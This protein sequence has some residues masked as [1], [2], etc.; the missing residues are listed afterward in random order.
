MGS[1]ATPAVARKSK[2]LRIA[3]RIVAIVAGVLALVFSIPFEVISITT[4]GIEQIHRVHNMAGATGFGLMLGLA[5]VLAGWRPEKQIAAF[6]MAL[7]AA[8]AF[9]IAGV[10][11]G[12][13]ANAGSIVIVVI[14]AILIALHPD[15]RAVFTFKVAV[16]IPLLVPSLLAAVP[17][18]AYALTQ[19]HLQKVGMVVAPHS[20]HVEMMHYESMAAVSLE[21]F[22][23]SLLAACRTQGW[24]VVAWTVAVSAILLGLVSVVYSDF[25]SA[26]DSPWSWL[27]I[28][29]GVVFLGVTEWQ[30]RQEVAG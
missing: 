12:D 15:R 22:L 17:A 11:S 4:S 3:F 14:L 30:T 18:I 7:V 2:G 24:R 1:D 27:A 19:A 16:S 5:L 21:I 13:P 8:V 20:P 9:I 29:W 23:V 28:V 26:F 6:Q 25:E 10:L